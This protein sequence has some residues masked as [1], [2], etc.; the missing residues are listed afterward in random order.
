M[1]F[2]HKFRIAAFLYL[3]SLA[4]AEEGS[5][6]FRDLALVS[7]IDK[8]LN[9]DLPFFYNFSLMGGYWNMPSAR[10][11]KEGEIGIG[12][13]RV[14]PYNIYGLNFQ[15]FEHVELSANYR[16][17]T[18]ILEP[19]FGSEGF[20]DDAERTGNIKLSFNLPKDGFAS[21]PVFAIGLEDF[22]GTKR[23]NAD[24]ILM[25][26]K[27]TSLNVEATL[28]WGKKRIKGWFGGISWTPLRQTDIPILKNITLVSEYD[29]IDY[30]NSPGEHPLGRDVKCRINSGLSYLLA[31]SLQA[32]VYYL[33][34][35]HFGFSGALRY[36]FGSSSGFFPKVDDPPLYKSPVDTEPLGVVR[37]KYLFAQEL[38]STFEKQGLDLYSVYLSQ[39]KSLWIKIINNAYRQE[40][41]LRE[42]IER[43]LA[44][45]IPSDVK[46]VIVTVEATAL[47]CHSYLFRTEDLFRYRQK[48]I[49]DFEI[50]TLSPMRE[51]VFLP[52][53]DEKLFSRKKSIWDISLKPRMINFF[54]S[55]T[56]KIK[57]NL[58]VVLTP[59]GYIADQVYYQAQVAYDALSSHFHASTID[60]INPSQLLNVRTDS[61]KYYQTNTFSLE[62]AYLQKSWN[63]GKGWFCRLAG[64]Y[65]EPAYGGEAL[66]FLYCP[67]Q[68]NWAIGVEEATVLKRRYH[69]VG[70]TR[71][72]RKLEGRVPHYEK[73]IGVQYFL[74]LYYTF[75]PLDL[76]LKIMAGQFLAKDKGARFEITRWFPSG[77]RGSLWCTVT[78]GH[79]KINGRI[80]YDKGFAFVIPL[81]F[82]LKKSSRNQI[83]YAMSAWLRDV[84]AFA[85]TGKQLYPILRLE[86]KS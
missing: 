38:A 7:E 85:E 34:G 43:V 40:S 70:F 35:K 20:G 31:D 25:T 79:D 29:A 57:Y 14:H 61:L 12:A 48:L 75:K 16:V 37:P 11:A 81:D 66:E 26:K 28:G 76:D 39:D 23:F 51:V 8:Q 83:G 82:F 32:S 68:S 74:D 53:S 13:A 36:P 9:D 64:G 6:L 80:Y 24:Y 44:A 73:F 55:S 52:P 45:L 30:K 4:Y 3:Y 62:M 19:T 47:L 71:K 49:G 59:D 50:T 67:V 56:G 54:G 65:F 46:E 2:K 22:I 84:G 42:R 69:G 10:M 33:R 86:R 77:F 58:A 18:G 21:L 60:R 1:L 27:W 17:Y 72:V 78:N 5:N 15:L 63:L 41:V